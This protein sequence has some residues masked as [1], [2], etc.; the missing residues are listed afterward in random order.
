MIIDYR[1]FTVLLALALTLGC[2]S[3]PKESGTV[4]KNVNCSKGTIRGVPAQDSKFLKL[5]IGMSKDEA[6][7]LIGA[8][9]TVQNDVNAFCGDSATRGASSSVEL[10]YEGQGRLVFIKNANDEKPRL[11][12]IFHNPGP[13]RK[14]GTAGNKPDDG[15][16][17]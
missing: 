17:P 1:M 15:S 5:Q 3:S 9:S 2:T 13:G 16:K 12:E 6:I 11:V 10:D 8:P 4:A 7:R 14:A